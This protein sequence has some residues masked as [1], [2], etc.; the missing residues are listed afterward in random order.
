M[1]SDHN[2]EAKSLPRIDK[3]YKKP[4]LKRHGMVSEV[5]LGSGNFNYFGDAYGGGAYGYS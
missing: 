1:G 5:T 2:D 4:T 3:V